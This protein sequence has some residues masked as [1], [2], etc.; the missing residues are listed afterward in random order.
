MRT[1]VLV[2]LILLS[3]TVFAET[4][5]ELIKAGHWKR[6]RVMIET[7]YAQNPKDV[8]PIVWMAQLKR[9][10]GDLDGAQK[11]LEQAIAIDPNSFEAHFHLADVMGDQLSKASVLKQMSGAGKLRHEIELSVQL[12]PSDIDA[13]WGL[14]QYY[15]QAPGIAGGSK[16]KAREQVA[17]ISKISPSWGFLA[18]AE[19]NNHEKQPA[20]DL[21]KQAYDAD[22]KNYNAVLAYANLA[23]SQKNWDLGER[24]GREM[25]QLDR[26]RSQGYSALAFAYV[27]QKKWNDLDAI[28]ADAEKNIPD[29]R[30]PFFNAGRALAD[31]GFDNARGERYLRYYLQQE[32]ELNGTKFSRVHWR[33]GQIMEKSSRKADAIAEYQTAVRL[34][35]GFE[36]AQKD[37]K[38]LK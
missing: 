5:D 12:K 14:M 16:D 6:A 31:T 32:P 2:L 4:P 33:L 37:L 9:V 36:P 27:S 1:R 15:M 34:E 28:L 21:Y 13:H 11:L 38:R 25:I 29:S 19:F 7:A 17:A 18:Q 35:P 22:P 3:V 24:L 26:G 30:A 20:A 8:K 10:L 23:L